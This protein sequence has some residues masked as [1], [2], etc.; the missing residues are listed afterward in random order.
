LKFHPLLPNSASEHH[1][2][3]KALAIGGRDFP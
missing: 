2:F 1:P 3:F